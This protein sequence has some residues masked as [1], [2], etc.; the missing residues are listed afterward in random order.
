MV[1]DN[2][3]QVPCSFAL[4]FFIIFPGG[5]L[6][7]SC[8]HCLGQETW[9]KVFRRGNP[10]CGSDNVTYNSQSHFESKICEAKGNTSLYV[11]H[12]G[13]CSKYLFPILIYP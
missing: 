5:Y 8:S 10:V 13:A 7:A 9:N 12:T 11:K 6:P 3:V 2:N 4:H 1:T